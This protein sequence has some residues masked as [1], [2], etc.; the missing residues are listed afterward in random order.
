MQQ[1]QGENRMRTCLASILMAGLLCLALPMASLHADVPSPERVRELAHRAYVWG[2]PMVDLYAILRSH[3]LDPSSGEYRAPLNQVGHVRTLGTPDD[4]V[5]VAPNLD[6]PY[7]FA[8]LDLRAEPVVVTVPPFEPNRYL[9]LQIS[10]LYTWIVGYVTPRTNGRGGGDFLIAREAW[11]GDVP[12]GIRKVFRSP[13]DLALGFFRT[14]LLSPDDLP[15]V[16][17]LQDRIIV[18]PLSVYLA[19]PGAPLP[20][21]MPEPVAPM[22][23]RKTPTDPAFFNILNWM[24]QFMPVLPEEVDLRR[25]MATIGVVAGE[26]FRPDATMQAAVIAGMQDGVAEIERYGAQVRSSAEIFGSREYLG[27][28]YLARAAG[29]MLGMLGNAAEE[30]LGVGYPAD[31]NGKPFDGHKRYRIHFKPD[32]LPPVDAF[33]SITVYTPQRQPYANA[34]GRY[35]INTPMVPSLL[36]DADGGFTIDIQHDSPGAER[37]ANWLPVPQGPF[38][39]TFRAYQP[40][41]EIRNGSWRAPPPVPQ[42]EDQ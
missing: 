38:I 40:R 39:L 2:Y 32:E 20:R 29:A 3:V 10:D 14:Q 31:A 16:H 28:N 36:R 6:T 5:V 9:S 37:E 30:F 23:V 11:K 26:P 1:I 4:K 21:G 41:E 12:P 18:R 17:R 27:N 25:D 8:W 34:L 7:S 33:W 13:T 42:G 15:N 22:D 19:K 24:L 35:T